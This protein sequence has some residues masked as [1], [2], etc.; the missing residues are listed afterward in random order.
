VKSIPGKTSSVILRP[1]ETRPQPTFRDIRFQQ[2]VTR[3][4]S[5]AKAQSPRTRLPTLKNGSFPGTPAVVSG[6]AGFSW[7]C[8]VFATDQRTAREV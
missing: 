6:Y 2:T 7:D 5:Q 4:F 1:R 8:L 3:D